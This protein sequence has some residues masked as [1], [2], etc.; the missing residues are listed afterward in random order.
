MH[1]ENLVALSSR[2]VPD[3]YLEEMKS[4][5]EALMRTRKF[6]KVEHSQRLRKA[7]VHLLGRFIEIQQ[8]R[9]LSVPRATVNTSNTRT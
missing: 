4:K 9:Q 5:T 7:N 3:D 1:R 6:E 8:G 2:A